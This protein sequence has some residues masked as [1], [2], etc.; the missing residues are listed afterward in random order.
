ML[1]RRLP[2]HPR[3]GRLCPLNSLQNNE[4]YNVLCCATNI[5]SA[6]VACPWFS[7]FWGKS[8]ARNLQRTRSDQRFSRGESKSTLV[9][10]SCQ[11]YAWQ[12]L[13]TKV[14]VLQGSLSMEERL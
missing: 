5:I 11:Y 12:R 3:R 8:S 4:I 13:R 6:V 7:H 14:L 1:R 9:E 2:D 10:P